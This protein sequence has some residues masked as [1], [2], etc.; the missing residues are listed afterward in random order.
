MKVRILPVIIILAILVPIVEAAQANQAV[1]LKVTAELAN[2]RLKPSIGSVIIRQIPQG[3][4]L[5]ALGRE[6]EWYLVKLEPDD[7]GNVSGYVHESLVLPL[8]ETDRPGRKAQPIEPIIKQPAGRIPPVQPPVIDQGGTV[9]A[10]GEAGWSVAVTAGGQYTVGGE[11]NSGAQ[12]FAD[13]F[14]TRSAVPGDVEISPA[15]LSF[16]F[17]GE[18][19]FDMV[20]GVALVLGADFYNA[21][22]DSQVAYARTKATDLFTAKPRFQ[23]IPL[24]LGIAFYPARTVALKAGIS[25]TIARCGYTFS[26]NQ[27]AFSQEMIGEAD[28]GGL[29]AWASLA[30]EFP[31]TDTLAFTIEAT[32]HYAPLHGFQG[33]GTYSDSTTTTATEETGKLWAYDYTQAGRTISPLILIR[34]QRPSEAYV[35]NAREAKIDF[36]GASLKV[37]IKVRF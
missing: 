23:A 12:A 33:T 32:G 5:E 19:S 21:S 31:L 11:I 26:Y 24:R 14:A 6:G 10:A 18:I 7:R 28:G 8:E 29:G 30:F 35:E 13:F 4:I 20:R 9:A 36:S 2:I 37:G 27:D 1:R 22:V 17:G 16:V 34:T 25:Y 15:H 3:D